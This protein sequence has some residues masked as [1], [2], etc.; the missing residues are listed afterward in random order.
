MTAFGLVLKY[1]LLEITAYRYYKDEQ[2]CLL[3]LLFPIHVASTKTIIFFYFRKIQV[4]QY[5]LDQD[6]K[7]ITTLQNI[8][9][10]RGGVIHR[11]KKK[12]L[13]LQ[14]QLEIQL[15]ERRDT[16][17]AE[18]KHLTY[19]VQNERHAH[20]RERSRIGYLT[21]QL[22]RANHRIAALQEENSKLRE[23]NERLSQIAGHIE[24]PEILAPKEHAVSRVVSVQPIAV[25]DQD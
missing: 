2:G 18:V 14:K 9:D 23:E 20:E 10:I 8:A 7:Q 17:E 22:E 25:F 11:E 12:N 6:Q 4:L 16:L 21:M 5:D 1:Y 19:E 24:N 3:I 15:R 13:E